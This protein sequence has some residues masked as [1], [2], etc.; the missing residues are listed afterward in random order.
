MIIWS[1]L[2]FLVA[3]ILIVT[4]LLA[5]II[6]GTITGN[7]SYFKD[8][9]MPFVI[10]LFIS[11]A[12]IYFLGKWLNTRKTKTYIDKGTGKEIIFKNNHG[13]FFIRMEYWGIIIFILTIIL[14]IKEQ[15]Q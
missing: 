10:S 13:F 9:S 6:T 1:G 8:N 5:S 2:G 11:C 14:L 3:I 12:I 15:L 4:T 7:D